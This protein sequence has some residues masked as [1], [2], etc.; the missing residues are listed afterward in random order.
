MPRG[1]GDNDNAKTCSI[2][3]ARVKAHWKD[4]IG[5]MSDIAKENRPALTL[6]DPPGKRL[7]RQ[8]GPGRG[9]WWV[10]GLQVVCLTGSG[11]QLA[12]RSER[13][14]PAGGA[15]QTAQLRDVALALEGRSLSRAAA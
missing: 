1:S 12:N 6:A 3:T 4:G 10:L 2:K 5:K 9:I 14:E 7:Q 13:A 8:G 11:Y 15:G